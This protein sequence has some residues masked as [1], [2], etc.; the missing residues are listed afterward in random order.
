MY[1]ILPY[2][3]KK[4]RELN[5]IVKPSKYSKYKIDIYDSNENYIFSG[6]ATGYSDYPHYILSKG[7][8]YADERK[9]LY[10]IRHKKEILKPYSKGWYIDQ[11]LW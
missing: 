9:R 7:K 6:G 4:A 1:D 5:I 8:I 11:L 2:T 10:N 3:F